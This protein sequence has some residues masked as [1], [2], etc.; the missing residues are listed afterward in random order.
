MEKPKVKFGCYFCEKGVDS[1]ELAVDEE[2]N[3]VMA[4]KSSGLKKYDNHFICKKCY[5]KV[6]IFFETN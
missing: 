5:E 2:G 4:K 6:N 1:K 3:V